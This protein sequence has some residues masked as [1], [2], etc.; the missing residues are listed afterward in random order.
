MHDG[1]PEVDHAVLGVVVGARN[2]RGLLL[3]AEAP[4]RAEGRCAARVAQTTLH[5]GLEVELTGELDQYE[6]VAQDLDPEP[7]APEHAGRLVRRRL[8]RRRRL[9]DRWLRGGYRTRA[10]RHVEGD[11]GG[12]LRRRVRH[13]DDDVAVGGIGRGRRTRLTVGFLVGD[14]GEVADDRECDV[15]PPLRQVQVAVNVVRAVTA[16]VRVDLDRR[17]DATGVGRELRQP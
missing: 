14:R 6:L 9:G 17:L 5:L 13:P 2:C 1:E 10:A 16:R 15:A 11:G 12:R 7:R 4:T 3:Q 8:R